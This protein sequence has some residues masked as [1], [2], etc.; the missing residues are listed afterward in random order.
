MRD[1]RHDAPWLPDLC[2]LPRL[3]AL[4]GI[5][6]LVVVVLALAPEA[7][8]TWTLMRFFS[9][10]GL[11]LWLALAVAVLLCKLRAPISRLP[12]RLGALLA[13]AV[14]T[15]VALLGAGI[16]HA[17]YAALGTQLLGLGLWRFASGAAAV[18]ALITAL[19]LR[20]FYVID[21]WAAQTQA[22]AR[23]EADALQARIRPHFLFNSMNLI[24]SLLRRDPV[25]AERA[26]L[27]LSDLFRAALG[28]GEGDST[29][30]AEC[31]LAAQYLSIESLRLGERL[32]VQWDKRDPLP[33]ELPLPRLTL[34]PL[35]ENAVLHG[36]SR[37]P[38]G[39]TV[40]IA[41]WSEGQALHLRVRNPAPPPQAASAPLHRGSGH[42]LRSIAHRLAWRFGPQA[43]V[44]AGWSDGYYACEVVLPLP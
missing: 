40:A 9:A 19:A 6:E 31:E 41:L 7:A 44:T 39:G 12:Q 11:V 23:A 3:V 33:W 21:R 28:A 20:H 4:L 30:A 22:N 15:M 38:Q 35:V 34:Q 32:Q 42:A 36:I 5:A 17:L 43:R 18:T 37:L 24:A 2:R 29:L 10:S 13:V 25:V 27:D 1:P 8:G 14:A 26:V 16:V